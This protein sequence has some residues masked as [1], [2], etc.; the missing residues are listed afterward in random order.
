MRIK[1]AK[2]RFTDRSPWKYL[3]ISLLIVGLIAGCDQITGSDDNSNSSDDT[4][5]DPNSN[6]ANISSFSASDE[7]ITEGET[8]TL[9]WEVS[10][11]DPIT[12]TL[13]PGSMDVSGET[14]IE[15]SPEEDTTYQLNAENEAGSDQSELSVSVIPE[16]VVAIEVEVNGL[17]AGMD[18]NIAVTNNDDYMQ[19]VS[20]NSA[21]T[22][23]PPGSYTV[24]AGPVNESGNTYI[25]NQGVQT[26][27]VAKAYKNKTFIQ[28][29]YSLSNESLYEIE[30]DVEA[31]EEGAITELTKKRG[32]MYLNFIR[33]LLGVPPVGY[34]F[35]SDDMVQKAS[36]MMA[37]NSDL[38]H[39][40]PEDWHCYSESGA[41]GAETSNL[42]IDLRN[43]EINATP[44]QFMILWA[45][46]NRVPSLGHRRWLIDPF[47]SQVAVGLVEGTPIEGEFSDAAGSAVRVV[48]GPE[49]NINNLELPF[50]A[51]PR[52][53]F[54]KELLTNNWFL[55]FSVLANTGSRFGANE[56]VDYSSTSITVQNEN[57]DELSV[58]DVSV[59]HTAFGLPNSLQWKVPD[60]RDNER[61]TVTISNVIVNGE[62]RDFS[63]EV[64]LQ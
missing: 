35:G 3:F 53:D 39:S 38:S 16:G 5:S 23:L 1:S 26:I 42:A 63:Y 59:D 56:Q 20:K 19:W 51:Y 55:S 45:D 34:D 64:Q 49:A 37:A 31:C 18:A 9:S 57:G 46:D 6:A 12:L 14:S 7:I 52:G 54:P 36:L 62:S 50:V 48:G 30:P 10:G 4:D 28:L 44:E 58:T 15:V 27:D 47:L 22:E 40:P 2:Q 61:Y 60:L 29:N 8:V 17:P 21:L 41:D 25:P 24:A 33:S 11:D 32:L 43:N 13:E